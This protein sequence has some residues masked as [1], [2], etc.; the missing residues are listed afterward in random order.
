MSDGP[1]ELRLF[2][3]VPVPD[4]PVFDTARR[5][6]DEERPGAYRWTSPDSLHVTLVFLGS[7]SPRLVP[8]LL[9]RLGQIDQRPFHACA[10]SLRV[11]QQGPGRGVLAFTV[12]ESENWEA[13][14]TLERAVREALG[15]AVRPDKRAFRPHVSIG[16]SRR[17][18]APHPVPK[19]E[20]TRD[21]ASSSGFIVDRIDLV[22]SHL[23]PEGSLYETLLSVPL[24]RS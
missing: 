24:K 9:S 19:I 6:V 3:G 13:W 7:T 17:G 18:H 23:R 2:V 4:R 22:Q 5:A 15:D 12:K 14:S 21:E 20:T 10:R 1:P 16:R 11:F 8:T